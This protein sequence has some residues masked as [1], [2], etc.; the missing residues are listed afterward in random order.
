MIQIIQKDIQ[1]TDDEL[2]QLASERALTIKGSILADGS[3]DP[4]RVFIIE[5]DTL[6]P[7]KTIVPEGSEKSEESD[8]PDKEKK[9]D[10]SIDSGSVIL[11]LK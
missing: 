7:E 2:R 3:I 10:K 11:T 6:E 4:K 9:S 1:V 5:A 8:K